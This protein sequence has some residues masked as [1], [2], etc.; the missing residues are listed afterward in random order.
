MWDTDWG[1]RR[2]QAGSGG[3]GQTLPNPQEMYPQLWKNSTFIVTCLVQEIKIAS[4]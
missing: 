3:G 1:K 4:S 2:Q